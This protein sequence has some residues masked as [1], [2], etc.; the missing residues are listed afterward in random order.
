METNEKAKKNGILKASII[1]ISI[2]SII[3]LAG[4]AYARYI[5]RINGNAQAKIAKWSFDSK[6]LNSAQTREVSDFSITRTDNKGDVD[7]STIAPGTSGEFII[8][9]DASRNRNFINIR[10]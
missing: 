9:I 10:N 5:T 7:S 6:I 4:F 1:L 8:E 2:V 3:A